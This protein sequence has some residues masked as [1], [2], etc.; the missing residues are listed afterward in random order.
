MIARFRCLL[1]GCSLIATDQGSAQI[2]EPE[3]GW[4]ALQ[5]IYAEDPVRRYNLIMAEGYHPQDSTGECRQYGVDL[6][7]GSN[8][9]HQRIKTCND[10]R[11]FVYMTENTQHWNDLKRQLVELHGFEEPADITGAQQV[12][13][14]DSAVVVFTTTPGKDG[15]TKHF[16]LVKRFDTPPQ[17]AC[18]P[19][20]ARGERHA[21]LIAAQNYQH[22]DYPDLRWPVADADALAQVLRKRYGFTCSVL[23]DPDRGRI[24]QALEMLRGATCDDEVIIYFAGHGE[25]DLAT[26]RGYWLPVDARPS[27][28]GHH[29]STS[30]LR[31]HVRAMSAGHILVISDACRGGAIFKENREIQRTDGSMVIM[32]LDK[33]EANRSRVVITS[34]DQDLVP[35]RS[36]F[37]QYLIRSLEKNSDAS[38][39]TSTL[40]ASI[41]TAVKNE[42]RADPL[43]HIPLPLYGRLLNTGDRN[44]A[45]ILRRKGR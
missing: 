1:I 37:S 16:I 40:Y 19:Q 39:E 21:L 31:D 20:P 9:W 7:V 18:T 33:L 44:G 43:A 6:A 27:D 36:L 3:T 41:L 45:L 10:S 14:R 24:I 35:D 11:E 32:D 26:E 2:S 38:M 23:H 5:R 8:Q 25:M 4:Q 42:R 13:V 17:A 29:I 15:L 28:R 34:G 30:D 22:P 12:Y